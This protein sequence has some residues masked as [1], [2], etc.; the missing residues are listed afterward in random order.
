MSMQLEIDKIL[1]ELREKGVFVIPSFI[2]GALLD[3]LN[4]EFNY[5]LNEPEAEWIKDH[6]NLSTAKF[7]EKEKIIDKYQCTKRFFSGA[8][9]QDLIDAYFE[10]RNIQANTKIWVIKDTEKITHIAQDLHFDISRTLKYFLYLNDV[11]EENG[12]F[13]CIP[14]SHNSITKGIR[15]KFRD[16]INYNNRHLSRVK[17]Q[18][19]K[20]MCVE[21]KAGTLIIFDT[22]VLHQAGFCSKG[23]RKIMRGQSSIYEY[24]YTKKG[25]L[26][27]IKNIFVKR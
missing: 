8:G 2:E 14:G 9:M 13:R 12:A 20:S 16:E 1:P 3:D 27:R 19:G 18:E 17:E 10:N 6:P 11:T 25:F 23:H 5:L 22:N 7:L 24:D 21:G 15:I 26:A 4:N